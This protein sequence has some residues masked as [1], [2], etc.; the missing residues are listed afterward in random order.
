MEP[1]PITG[2]NV[3]WCSHFGEQSASVK[4]RGTVMSLFM[5]ETMT[6]FERHSSPPVIILLSR[7]NFL[8]LLASW[9]QSN[10]RQLVEGKAECNP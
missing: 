3:K 2:E 6:D 8:G 9:S 10:F 5:L 1:S 4:E 7:H